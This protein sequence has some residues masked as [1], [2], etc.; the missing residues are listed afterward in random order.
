[1]R[2][3]YLIPSLGHSGAS[4]QLELLAQ[5]LLREKVELQ[6]CQLGSDNAASDRLRQAGITVHS[7]NLK[8][9]FDP[10]PLWRLRG[11][12]HDFQPD[13]IHA[14]QR[15][16]LRL[17]GLVGRRFLA[18]VVL[19]QPFRWDQRCLLPALDR[20][21]LRGVA[22]IVVQGEAEAHLGHQ[23]GLFLDKIAV[24]PPGIAHEF[25]PTAADGKGP[26]QSSPLAQE[27][28][29]IVCIG[30]LEGHKGYRDALWAFDML[31]YAF[32]DIHLT[33][34]GDGPDRV[35]LERFAHCVEYA[36]HIHFVRTF[37]RVDA[38]LA[39]A[40]VCWVP[41][42]RGGGT[43]AT[44]EAMRAGLPIVACQVPNL[45]GLIVNGVSGFVV[46]PGNRFALAQRTRQL[47]LD[48]DLSARLAAIARHRA[49]HHFAADHLI[50]RCRR[51]YQEIAA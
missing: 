30:P 13:L 22:R 8:R 34:L 23:Q 32:P 24:I 44:L 14:W 6:V 1:M 29:E 3:L 46:P 4:R 18:R 15:Q 43:Q 21:L 50:H 48:P 42:R 51:M 9:A 5:G 7:L 36:D 10:V 11:L 45:D 28:R 25:A 27:V 2:I 39:Q 40:D 47:F 35:P 37:A 41:S 12:L 16:S 38:H 33:F 20:W 49:L 17:L 26:R 19:S 31:R